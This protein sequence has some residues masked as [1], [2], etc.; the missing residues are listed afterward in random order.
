MI[1]DNK[2]ERTATRRSA[3]GT[4]EVGQAFAEL[5]KEQTRSNVE[6]FQALTR[7][8]GWDQVARIQSELLRA[9]FEHA[10]MF[11]RRYLE[12]GQAVTTSAVSTQKQARKSV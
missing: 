2:V 7:A 8:V 4:T 5:V 11:I 10:A 9:S 6:A 3:E 1:K 12:V